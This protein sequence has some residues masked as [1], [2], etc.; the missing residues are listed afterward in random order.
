MAVLHSETT[1]VSAPSPLGLA[2]LGS[3]AAC[4]IAI[5]YFYIQTPRPPGEREFSRNVNMSPDSLHLLT[6]RIQTRGLTF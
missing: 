3:I 2:V 1:E 6:G 5:G 4:W